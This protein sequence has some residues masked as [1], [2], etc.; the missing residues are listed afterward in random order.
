MAT[1]NMSTVGLKMLREN[2]SSYVERASKGEHITVSDHGRE[3]AELGPLSP[4]REAVLRLVAAGEAR[5][6]G[7]KPRPA[8]PVAYDGP[9][10]AEAVVD[11]RDDPL[12]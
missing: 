3:V 5:W 7:S 11:G 1:R 10:L 12:P 8:Q 4:E 2:L 9:A 6:N